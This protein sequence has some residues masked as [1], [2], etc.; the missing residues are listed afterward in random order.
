MTGALR[1]EQ[2]NTLPDSE[3]AP[4]GDKNVEHDA[5]LNIPDFLDRRD[6]ATYTPVSQRAG[7]RRRSRTRASTAKYLGL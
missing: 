3:A 7:V 2:A 1:E 6:E 4:E 5:L